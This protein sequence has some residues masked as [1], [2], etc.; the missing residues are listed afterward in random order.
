MNLGLQEYLNQYTTN[1]EQ[2]ELFMYRQSQLQ[3]K[4]AREIE[5]R[6]R[7]LQRIEA[8]AESNKITLFIQS[9]Y[10]S[11]SKDVTFDPSKTNA[12]F[13]KRNGG[14]IILDELS[15][16]VDSDIIQFTIKSILNATG[17]YVVSL[18]LP[19][20][21]ILDVSSSVRDLQLQTTINSVYIRSPSGLFGPL[22]VKKRD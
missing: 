14:F 6:E 3:R 13:M 5:A 18:N 7:E 21:E 12:I 19:N 9:N 17:K 20:N 15:D 16:T 11:S 10:E 2:E 4:E 22:F 8:S 1:E